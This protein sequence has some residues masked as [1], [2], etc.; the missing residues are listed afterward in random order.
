M[1]ELM[2]ESVA[3]EQKVEKRT[4]VRVTSRLHALTL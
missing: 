1:P 2:T 3:P 4:A